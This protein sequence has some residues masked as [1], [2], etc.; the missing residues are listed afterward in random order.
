ML[1]GAVGV[2]DPDLVVGTNAGDIYIADANGANQLQLTSDP[3]KESHPSFSPDGKKILFERILPDF[4]REIFVKDLTTGAL[5]RLTW[6][7]ASDGDA[8]WSPDGT[9]IA[10]VSNRVKPG[11]PSLY[12]IYV[13]SATGANSVRIKTDSTD[14]QP[15][16]L[17]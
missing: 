11:I 17:H 1:V 15:R 4:N 2:H 12:Q 9:Q 6:N 16:W 10:F 3:G 5:K 13:M 7:S 8:T 14:W